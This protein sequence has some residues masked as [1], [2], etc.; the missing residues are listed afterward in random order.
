MCIYAWKW[1]VCKRARMIDEHRLYVMMWNLQL[2]MVL[3]CSGLVLSLLNICITNSLL[4]VSTLVLTI[5]VDRFQGRCMRKIG[6]SQG[7]GFFREIL[8]IPNWETKK[9]N[10]PLV[11]PHAR[12]ISCTNKR[13]ERVRTGP[14]FRTVL[15]R[16]TCRRGNTT[17]TNQSSECKSSSL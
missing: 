7:T 3:I 17:T 2:D 1:N 13:R 4:Y 16:S 5:C 9:T 14:I 11:I 12:S 15:G 8:T 10:I 6:M